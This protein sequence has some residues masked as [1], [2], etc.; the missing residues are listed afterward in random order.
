MHQ[1][2]TGALLRLF[3]GVVFQCVYLSGG[4]FALWFLI[5]S[6]IEGIGAGLITYCSLLSLF[7]FVVF[8][9]KV[10]NERLPLGSTNPYQK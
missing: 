5:V 9:R 2:R 4:L 3:F 1:L 6:D 8:N 7:V 10:L